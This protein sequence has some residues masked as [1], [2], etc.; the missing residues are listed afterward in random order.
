[1]IELAEV[2]ERALAELPVHKRGLDQPLTIVERAVD[3]ER[4][5]VTTQRRELLLLNLA[6]LPFRVEYDYVD[7]LHVQKPVGYGA[8]RIADVATSTVTRSPPRPRK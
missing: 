6:D 2:S 7:T 3:L 8:A 4:R 1:M 5:N